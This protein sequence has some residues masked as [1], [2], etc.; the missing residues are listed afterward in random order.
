MFEAQHDWQ[1]ALRLPINSVNVL[2]IANLSITVLV[3]HMPHCT[4]FSNLIASELEHYFHGLFE[5]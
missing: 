1:P 4:A 5:F 3:F 2:L